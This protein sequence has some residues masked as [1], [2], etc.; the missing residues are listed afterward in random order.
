MVGNLLFRLESERQIFEAY[1]KARAE[2]PLNPEEARARIFDSRRAEAER[3]PVVK[4]VQGPS[5]TGSRL[6]R[7]AYD[8]WAPDFWTEDRIL[9]V[10]FGILGI[11]FSVMSMIAGG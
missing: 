10:G 2:L 8:M 3:K 6:P 5:I 11:L 9:T 1:T 4:A 7:F